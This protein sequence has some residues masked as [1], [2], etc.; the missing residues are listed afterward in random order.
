[1]KVTFLNKKAFVKQ[2]CNNAATAS[3]VKVFVLNDEAEGRINYHNQY[4]YVF[5]T[6]KTFML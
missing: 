5:E 4:K 2:A 3:A 6:T 1:M